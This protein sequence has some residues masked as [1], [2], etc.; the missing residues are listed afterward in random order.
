MSATFR[1]PKSRVTRAV[2]DLRIYVDLHKITGSTRIS[3]FV[4]LIQGFDYGV[5]ACETTTTSSSNRII[6]YNSICVK[7]ED[8]SSIFIGYKA[9]K[10]A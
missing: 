3:L 6:I 8:L 4:V 1:R 7:E 2:L 9:K 10:E 5:E